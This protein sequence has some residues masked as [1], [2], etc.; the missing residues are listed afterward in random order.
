MQ[1]SYET[2]DSVDTEMEQLLNEAYQNVMAMLQRNMAAYEMIIDALMHQGQDQTL[3]GE[4]V[5]EI[6][7]AHGC[8]EDLDRR[9]VERAA[10]M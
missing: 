6:V 8:K 1:V 7:D 4:Q 5:R 3:T 9:N 10:F 2:L